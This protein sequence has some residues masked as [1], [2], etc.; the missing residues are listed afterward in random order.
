MIEEG[1]EIRSF[2][3]LNLDNMTVG[4]IPQDTP[5]EQVEQ[6]EEA[7]QLLLVE[8]TD[9]T[10]S[11]VTAQEVWDNN[12]PRVMEMHLVT[13]EHFVPFLEALMDALEDMAPEPVA[14]V[15]TMSRAK[16]A[17]SKLDV[18]RTLAEAM[19]DMYRPNIEK[20]AADAQ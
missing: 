7:G 15:G 2:W 19:L 20:E 18:L 17:P 1:K 8:Y 6:V 13:Q 11:Q 3:A 14:T 4:V 12:H 9:G 5:L 16:A 10:R